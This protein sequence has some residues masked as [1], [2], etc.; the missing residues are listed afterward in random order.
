M[1][2][3]GDARPGDQVAAECCI[4]LARRRATGR[5]AAISK[6]SNGR[7]PGNGC[8]DPGG[9]GRQWTRWLGWAIS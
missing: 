2:A 4:A 3:R 8:N 5:S 6:R 1:A 9:A 7:A